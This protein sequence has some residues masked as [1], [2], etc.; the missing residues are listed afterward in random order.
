MW[1]LVIFT[2]WVQFELSDVGLLL[3]C[4][5]S[6]TLVI[7]EC[8][9]SDTW[10][11]GICLREHVP[12]RF[13]CLRKTVCHWFMFGCVSYLMDVS[14]EWWSSDAEMCC[15]MLSSSLQLLFFLQPWLNQTSHSKAH[16]GLLFKTLPSIAADK[17]CCMWLK[18]ALGYTMFPCR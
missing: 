16:T 3:E 13:E 12:E 11:S 14:L 18:I 4:Y 8:Y 2:K 9:F 17:H 15:L 6:V 5:L 10:V 7:L 1:G